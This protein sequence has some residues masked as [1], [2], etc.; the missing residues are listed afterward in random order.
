MVWVFWICVIMIVYTY[1]GY[2]LLLLA[3]TQCYRKRVQTGEFTPTVSV[4][5]PYYNEERRIGRKLE[6]TLD[7]D[8]PHDRMELIAASDCSTDGSDDIVASYAARGVKL[9]RL[10]QRRGK[11]HAQGHALSVVH[12]D[13]IVFTDASILLPREAIRNIV[14]NFIDPVVGCVSSTDRVMAESQSVN[15]EGLYVRYDMFLRKRESLLGSTSGMS[16]SFY[17]ARRELCDDWIPNM[18]ND[19]YL[20]LQSVMRGYRAILDPRAV[21]YY[22]LVGTHR[23]EFIRKVRTVVHGLQVMWRF[24]GILNPLR[25]GWYSVQVLSHKLLRWL[26]PLFMGGVLM[27]NMFLLTRGLVYQEA[28]A[29]QSA[30]YAAAALGYVRPAWQRLFLVRVPYFLIVANLS[31]VVAWGKYLSGERYVVWEPSRR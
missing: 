13:I 25:Y 28:L 20:P 18:S 17:A 23:Q 31:I 5:I 6:N 19:F 1:F 24:R 15:T 7:L 11:H 12:G 30:F 4:I 14:R 9:V 3:L 22:T 10:D 2:P 8:Y 27:S 26:V 29:I 21:G 16:G